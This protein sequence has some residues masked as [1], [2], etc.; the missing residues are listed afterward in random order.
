MWF[1]PHVFSAILWW[2]LS[3]V[4]LIK[5]IR[6]KHLWT[7]SSFCSLFLFLLGKSAEP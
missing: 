2:N 6:A 3:W 1:G 7:P 4:Q 5:W